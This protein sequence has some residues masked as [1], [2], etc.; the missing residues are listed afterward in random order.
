MPSSVWNS[1]MRMEMLVL[2]SLELMRPEGLVKPEVSL[3]NRRN[4][5]SESS[6]GEVRYVLRR[7]AKVVTQ[8][9]L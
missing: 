9:F 5:V 6:D 8:R 7:L 1:A 2:G 3:G 4:L